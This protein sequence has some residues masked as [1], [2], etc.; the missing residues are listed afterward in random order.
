MHSRALLVGIASLL[1]TGLFLVSC[2]PETMPV[3][4]PTSPHPNTHFVTKEEG[5]LLLQD[6]FEDG[7]AN[8]GMLYAATSGGGVFR[9]ELW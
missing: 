7:M 8:G 3:P 9:L 5:L 2:T 4:A 1:I 6:D